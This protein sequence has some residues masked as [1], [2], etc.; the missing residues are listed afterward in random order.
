[1]KKSKQADYVDWNKAS[2]EYGRRA[3]QEPDN[4][5]TDLVDSFWSVVGPLEG[6]KVLDVGCGPGVLSE[7]LRKKGASVTGIDF[8]GGLIVQARK[9]SPKSSFIQKDLTEG[10]P[11][12]EARFDLAL[13]HMVLM[14]IPDISS[15]LKGL[16]ENGLKPGGQFII[17]LPHPVFFNNK[18]GKDAESGEPAKMIRSYLRHSVIRVETFGGHNHYHR[19]ISFYFTELKQAGFVVTDFIEPPHRM[20]RRN[21]L[22]DWYLDF[23]VYCLISARSS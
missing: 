10:L 17:T 11:D 5:L 18:R 21:P 7:I 9:N 20:A 14:D 12:L 22:A 15:L 1:M 2:E 23:P 3:K 13:A 8:S 19:P 6:L 16:R 4:C